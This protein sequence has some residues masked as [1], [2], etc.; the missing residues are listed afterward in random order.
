MTNK[1]KWGEEDY[2]ITGERFKE[3]FF[4]NYFPAILEDSIEI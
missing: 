3:L 1:E 4:E 2:I